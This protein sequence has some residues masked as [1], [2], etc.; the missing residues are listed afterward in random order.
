MICLF[1]IVGV[2]WMSFL[3]RV[4]INIRRDQRVKFNN[5]AYYNHKIT[6][7]NGKAEEGKET[8]ED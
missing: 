5:Q 7:L 1:V 3:F 8:E 4:I 2:V 6:Q